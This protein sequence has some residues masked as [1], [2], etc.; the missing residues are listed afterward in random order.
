M[1]SIEKIRNAGVVG[2]GG[3]GFPT[4]VKLAAKADTVLINAASCEPLL[5]SDIYL[6]E[7]DP[8]TIIRGIQVVMNAVG[9][10]TA[11]ICIKKK[12]ADAIRI[13][14]EQLA[15]VQGIE[16]FLMDDF[17]PAG[18]E[19]V[20]VNEALGRI[21]PE[22]GL[23][24]DVGV[25]VTNV[26]TTLNIARAME[27]IPVTLRTLN[28]AGEVD[29]PMVVRVPIGMP[30]TEVLQMAGGLRAGCKVIDGGPM[31]GRVLA[32][33][34]KAYV[35]KTT[36]ALLVLPENHNVI[37]QKEAPVDQFMRIS[38]LACC[39]CTLCTELCPR[40]QLG[41][42]LHPHLIM[43]SLTQKGAGIDVEEIQ[44]QALLC[45]ACGICEK[46]ACPMQISPR[47][48]N[49]ALKNQIKGNPKEVAKHNLF[50]HPHTD[51]RRVPVQRLMGKIDVLKY[52]THPQINTELSLCKK[53]GISLRQHIGAA[54]IPVVK[55]GDA[56]REGQLIAK[57]PEK[58]LGARLHASIK[59]VV[60]VVSDE[61]IVIERSKS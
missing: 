9:A 61:L 33:P 40:W 20:M 43:R 14:G 6:L 38:R 55:K 15:S 11:K 5:T 35:T 36:S 50:R 56:V 41:H 1:D 49:M 46:W 28:I 39:Q 37:A 52:Y 42:N 19:Q 2:G 18:D 60:Q 3:A 59:G 26:E 47:E 34:E 27:D 29:T 8:Q 23:P 4:H 12:H 10:T 57:I 7:S 58:A 31:M 24:L 30:V 13:L 17:Y 25:V 45:C 22:G 51:E 53:V 16:L 44:K 48:V 32:D 21:V 54:A